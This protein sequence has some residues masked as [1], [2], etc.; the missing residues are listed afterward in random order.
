MNGIL[1]LL[2]NMVMTNRE[3]LGLGGWFLPMGPY[4]L[5][6]EVIMGVACVTLRFSLIKGRYSV[7]LQWDST[8]KSLTEWANIYGAGVL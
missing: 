2:R 4:P 1:N 5:K 8:R 7:H 6:D 3:E